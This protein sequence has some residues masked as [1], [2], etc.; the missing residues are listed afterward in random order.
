MCAVAFVAAYGALAFRL[1]AVSFAPIEASASARVA[2]AAPE[3]VHR[4]D[5]LDRNGVILATDLPMIALEIAG[6]ETWDAKETAA[7][8]AKI[9]PD[10]DRGE[11][12]EKLAAGRY[13]DV[14]DDLTPAQR[15]EVF[16]LG[17]PGVR[18]SERSRR[19][20]PQGRLAAHVVGH[21][22]L[23]KGGV[24]GLEK[25][26][27]S[28]AGG[29]PLRA[30]IDVRVQQAL[31]DELVAALGEHQALAAWGAVLDVRTGEVFALASLPNFDPNDPGAAPPDWRRNRAVYD[32]YELGSAFKPFTAAAALD[33]GVAAETTAY[34]ARGNFRVADRVISDF[35][36]ENRILSFSEVIEYSSNIGMARMA[37]DLGAKKQEAAL[38]ALG[39]T[40]RLPIELAENRDPELPHRW[41]PVETATIA[42]GHGISVTPLHLVAAYSAVVNG[43]AYETPTFLRAD[44]PRAGAQ[45]FTERTSAI[46]RRVLRRVVTDGTAKN[47]EAPGYYPIGKTATAEKP[48]VG[49]YDRNARIASFVGAFPGYAPRYVALI[50]LDDPKPS[51]ATH[52]YATAGWNAAPA[53]AKLVD[54]IAP[55][56]GV[57]S[58]NEAT[59]LAGFYQGFTTADARDVGAPEGRP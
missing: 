26:L 49:G 4:A 14:K 42:Y 58:V 45:V 47:A 20:Y 56:L 34:D 7:R 41:G 9:F 59:A 31:E 54:R 28:V 57:P 39:L 25:T 16:A 33:A 46:M 23:G 2:A 30:S 44:A 18:F 48:A 35:H 1:A 43:G 36:G 6:D 3:T 51:R 40:K 22:E 19:F 15:D 29:G 12:E 21:T 27:D 8:L 38:K 24:M 11:L 10:I 17:L 53:F 37:G 55:L 52:G 5:I 50:S 13:V 32:R